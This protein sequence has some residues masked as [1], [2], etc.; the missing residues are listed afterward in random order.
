MN[1]LS[2]FKEKKKEIKEI[3]LKPQR[4]QTKP[5]MERRCNI[6]R[7]SGACV[8]SL[9]FKL[10]LQ[11]LTC[12]S[13]H[14]KPTFS[15]LSLSLSLYIHIFIHYVYNFEKNPLHKVTILLTDLA[16]FPSTAVK[17]SNHAGRCM[18]LTLHHAWLLP[19]LKKEV[20][21]NVD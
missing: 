20:E 19:G 2:C 6:K 12:V 15:G 3:K 18:Y 1:A 11:N 10:S 17:M 4:S 7:G 8:E 9:F 16:R 13:K 14:A 21:W 5:E